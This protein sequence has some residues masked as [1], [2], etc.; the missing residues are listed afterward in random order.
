MQREQ[1]SAGPDRSPTVP[2]A[3]R[4]RRRRGRPP[5]L[6]VNQ[7]TDAVIRLGFAGTTV[8]QVADELTVGPAT[9]YRYIGTR[10]QMLASA[11]DRLIVATPW[12]PTDGP[13]ST[14]CETRAL[15]LW[16]LFARHPGAASE[17]AP[18]PVPP[19]MMHLYDDLTASLIERGFTP[20][21]A[22]LAADTVLDLT[23]DHRL[24]VER[25][26][27]A[28]ETGGLTL[29]DELTAT[30]TGPAADPASTQHEAARAAMR[31]AIATPP[32]DWLEAKLD[33]AIAGIAR[34]LAPHH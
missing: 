33:L 17:L 7:I 14:V 6:D 28:R 4:A 18:G 13:W 30:W 3:G 10:R 16:D 23:I 2:A 29:R 20:G 22:L 26:A 1:T 11:F 8:D 31:A 34:R 9:L 5:K 19:A 15:A 12:P 24:G 21:D 32:R 27:L 25:L